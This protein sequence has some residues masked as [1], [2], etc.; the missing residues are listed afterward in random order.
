MLYRAIG[1]MSGSSLDGLDIVYAHYEESGGKWSAEIQVAECIPYNAG[2]E[3]RLREAA[4]LNALDYQLLDLE[5]G[6]WLGVQV[7]SFIH[8]N[9]LDFK[10]ALVASHGHT[11]FHLPAKGLTAQIGD[12]ASIAAATGLPV[13]SGLRAMD[14]ALGGQGAP[15]VPIGERLLFSSH[16]FLLNLGGIANVSANREPYLAFDVCP[17][18]RV[19]NMLAM[20]KGQ[21]FDRDGSM[22]RGGRID[23]G[24]LQ[25]LNKLSYYSRS[26]PKSLGN[27]FGTDEVYPLILQRGLKVE[28]ALATMTEHVAM[29]VRSALMQI[30]AGAAT[31]GG[32]LLV[33]GGGALNGFL[34]ERIHDHLS[35]I[36]ISTV[37][38]EKELVE[39]KEALIMGLIGL[40]RW[41]EE[42][43]VLASVTGAR[44]NSVGG[45]LWMGQEG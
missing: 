33:T 36:N 3:K 10:V 39:C 6:Q 25:D 45:A 44:R 35:L 17:A 8:R 7:Q 13:V 15:I 27:E 9:Q 12:G 37:V 16:D 24:L 42:T 23:A 28:D 20:L 26:F 11:V 19:L 5:Y 4:T 32:Q 30:S 40:L 22:A 2:W 38:P 41:R 31:N 18:N 29:Q 34:V 43:N 1:L 14:M 21:P